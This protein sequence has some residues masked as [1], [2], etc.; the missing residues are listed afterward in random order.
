[1][2]GK[3]SALATLLGW[4]TDTPRDPASLAAAGITAASIPVACAFAAFALT[5]ST[6]FLF[7]PTLVVV[8]ALFAWMGARRL[9]PD[10]T[11]ASVAAD[12]AIAGL[13]TGA[14]GFIAGLVLFAWPDVSAGREITAATSALVAYAVLVPRAFATP[15]GFRMRWCAASA[16]SV[17]VAML[18]LAAP[19]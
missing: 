10:R 8:P 4:H 7:V 5:P 15:S 3:R 6:E 14:A 17:L 1:M 18:I 11:R 19:P 2:R 12:G 16:A 13:A 9:W